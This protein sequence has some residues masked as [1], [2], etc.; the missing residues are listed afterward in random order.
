MPALKPDCLVPVC[1]LE[2]ILHLP[3]FTEFSGLCV[4]ALGLGL[5]MPDSHRHPLFL[6]L[7]MGGSWGSLTLLYHD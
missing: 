6:S 3:Y 2:E 5:G 1:G 4:T 7:Y